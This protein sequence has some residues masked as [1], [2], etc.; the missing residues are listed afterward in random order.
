MNESFPFTIVSLAL[1]ITIGEGPIII[2]RVE[3][4]IISC[5]NINLSDTMRMGNFSWV[6]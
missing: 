4:G 1:L 3:M 2:E 5:F 6:C